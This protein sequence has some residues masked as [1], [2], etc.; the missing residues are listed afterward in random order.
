MQGQLTSLASV[1]IGSERNGEPN[2]TRCYPIFDS[3]TEALVELADKG[4]GSDDMINT[5]RPC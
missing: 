4:I 2:R 5:I 1:T 3:A